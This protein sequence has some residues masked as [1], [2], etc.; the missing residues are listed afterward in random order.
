MTAKLHTAF[1]FGFHGQAG[2]SDLQFGFFVTFPMTCFS[3]W[4]AQ[5][6]Y[7]R[8]HLNMLSRLFQSVSTWKQYSPGLGRL[9]YYFCWIGRWILLDSTLQQDFQNTGS[10][11]QPHSPGIA[12]VTQTESV[13]TIYPKCVLDLKGFFSLKCCLPFCEKVSFANKRAKSHHG[14]MVS[15]N[16]SSH[17]YPLKENMKLT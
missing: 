3:K 14:I 11:P 1:C 16:Y 7:N 2:L 8:Y 13:N 12:C 9:T 15:T 5:S 4:Q 6:S 10:K 17:K